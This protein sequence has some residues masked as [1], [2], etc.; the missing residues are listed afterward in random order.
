MNTAIFVGK[1]NT[2]FIADYQN[3]GFQTVEHQSLFS[4]HYYLSQLQ[5]SVKWSSIENTDSSLAP[6]EK[7]A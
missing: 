4:K 6:V 1:K 2:H 5:F 7:I 3:D